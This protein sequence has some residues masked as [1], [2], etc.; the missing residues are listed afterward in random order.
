MPP[1]V[2]A[3]PGCPDLDANG[4]LDCVETILGN[5]GF[6]RD[7]DGWEAEPDV[8]GGWEANDARER[9]DSG[10]AL[11]RFELVLD[12]D[13]RGFGGLYQCLAAEVGGRY[14]MAAQVWIPAEQGEGSSGVQVLFMPEPNCGGIPLGSSI[15]ATSAVE[16]WHSV[17]AAFEIPVGVVSLKVRLGSV[18]PFRDES[19]A[20]LID[21][22][23]LRQR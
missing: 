2:E 20:V 15:A 1:G 17:N 12:S 10:S 23:L 21:N 9:G 3:Q 11:V 16:E 22:V 13:A 4:V 5:A 18:K 14:Q 6:D 7:T 19:F 8:R